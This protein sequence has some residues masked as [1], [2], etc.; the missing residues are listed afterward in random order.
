M[1]P[2]EKQMFI[3]LASDTTEPVYMHLVYVPFYLTSV[4]F[5]EVVNIL[6]ITLYKTAT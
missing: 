2:N 3:R 5:L 1:A 6:V 4:M